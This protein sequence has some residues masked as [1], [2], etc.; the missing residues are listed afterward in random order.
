MQNRRA[1]CLN[2]HLKE[3]PY[4]EKKTPDNFPFKT[5]EVIPGRDQ[6][7]CGADRLKLDQSLTKY[8]IKYS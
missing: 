6:H 7:N 5:T 3:E 4:Y 2:K 1:T 8:V